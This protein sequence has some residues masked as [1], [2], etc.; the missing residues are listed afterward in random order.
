MVPEAPVD[1]V[2]L[3]ALAPQ[4]PVAVDAEAEVV[5]S[6]AAVEDASVEAAAVLVADVAGAAPAVEPPTRSETRAAIAAASTTAT[7]R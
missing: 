7:S 5:G 3:A 4:A 2:A 1:R 6:G